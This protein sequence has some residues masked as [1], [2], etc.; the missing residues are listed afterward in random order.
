MSAAHFE[1][2]Q[3]SAHAAIPPSVTIIDAKVNRNPTD[4]SRA[5]VT[6]IVHSHDASDAMDFTQSGTI[7]DKG[8]DLCKK[9]A[10]ISQ[11]GIDKRGVS[12]YCD[13]EGKPLDV[14][15]IDPPEPGQNID[16]YYRVTHSYIG[17]D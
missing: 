2:P 13:K 16:H 15:F 11:V 8:I 1:P 4:A 10:G 9:E 7:M 5:E 3:H 6:F 12:I 17:I 14:G